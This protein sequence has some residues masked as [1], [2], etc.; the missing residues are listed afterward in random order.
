MTSCPIH[1]ILLEELFVSV[2]QALFE[3]IEGSVP[4]PSEILTIDHLTWQ[5]L[6]GGIVSLPHGPVPGGSWLRMLRALL[7]E[8]I[9]PAAFLKQYRPTVLKIWG[10]LGLGIRQGMRSAAIPFE[11]LDSERQ[12]LLMRL[13]GVAVELLMTGA[14][15]RV[16]KDALLFTAEPGEHEDRPVLSQD[17]SSVQP[18]Q[19]R[20]ERLSSYEQAWRKAHM[21]LEDVERAMRRDQQTTRQMR[22]ILLEAHPTPKKIEA[23]DRLFRE[24]GYLLLDDVI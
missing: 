20:P 9:L 12:F 21:A 19:A 7:D 24:Q 23:I 14:F 17:S 18:G 2:G 8:L 13:A 4:A 3:E 15:K 5:A 16:G 10:T 1:G 11:L 6:E 22:Q